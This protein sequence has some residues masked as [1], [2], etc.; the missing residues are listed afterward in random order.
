MNFPKKV[1]KF[2]NLAIK[3]AEKSEYSSFRHGAI[4]CK[5]GSV[6]QGSPNKNCLCSFGER[7]IHYKG[8]P[9]VHAELGS[10]LGV[11]KTNTHNA[12]VYVVRINRNGTLMNSRPC[13]MCQ[14]V[15][16]FVGV[17]RVFYSISDNEYG[18]LNLNRG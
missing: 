7:F 16:F 13:P 14:G 2:F 4:V 6:I 11:S 10:I 5:G 17:K 15:L 12:T 3:E 9:T 18:V 8:I 1:Q